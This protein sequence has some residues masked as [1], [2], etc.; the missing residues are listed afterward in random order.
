MFDPRSPGEVKRA[1]DL[2]RG[3]FE[4]TLALGGSISGEHG[5]GFTKMA[6][7]GDQM[8]AA[9]MALQRHVKRAFDPRGL[10]NPG[11]VVGEN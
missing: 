7:L 2:A 8:G 6:Y 11:K 9:G 3:L 1:E 4:A 5:I 10:V